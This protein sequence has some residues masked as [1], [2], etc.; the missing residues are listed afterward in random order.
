MDSYRLLKG[1]FSM[2]FAG[3]EIPPKD[4]HVTKSKV[5]MLWAR[6]DLLGKAV[7]QLLSTAK[8]WKIIRIY[9]KDNGC[10]LA[11]ELA[12]VKPDVFI[13]QRGDYSGS[14]TDTLKKL[15]LDHCEMK[16]ITISL[17]NN[18]VEVYDKQTIWIK[19]VSDLL[20]MIEDDDVPNER[21]GEPHA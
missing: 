1:P 7:Q 8:D 9:D 10:L 20:S 12:R 16:I 19:G 18:M 3:L 6:E 13:I 5:A 11:R 2:V 15:M 21:G 14:I 17:E 4:V